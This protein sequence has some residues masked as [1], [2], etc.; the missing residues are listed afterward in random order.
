[1][2]SPM[3][4]IFLFYVHIYRGRRQDDN[5]VYNQ[6]AQKFDTQ[7]FMCDIDRQIMRIY[8]HHA[9]RLVLIG[10]RGIIEVEH[11]FFRIHASTLSSVSWILSVPFSLNSW[12][13]VRSIH[14]LIWNFVARSTSF[15]SYL[16]YLSMEGE[17]DFFGDWSRGWH[18]QEKIFAKVLH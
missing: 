18:M 16:D 6:A 13:I 11:W 9:V 4:C 5:A 17:R 15:Q 14:L 10:F 2:Y 3:N 7:S 12:I 8:T 1:M